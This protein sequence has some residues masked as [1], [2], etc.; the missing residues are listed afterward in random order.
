MVIWEYM[1][2]VG[3]NLAD[4]SLLKIISDFDGRVRTLEL[5][6]TMN[7]LEELISEGTTDPMILKLWKTTLEAKK[8]Q[9]VEHQGVVSGTPETSDDEDEEDDVHDSTFCPVQLQRNSWM[10][11]P[12]ERNRQNF[13]QNDPA[14]QL[15]VPH[16]LITYLKPHEKS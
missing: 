11:S 3:E 12:N 10:L 4:T 9:L 15:M 5:N 7:N 6:R 8:K 16:K 1:S 2:K 14:L 13:Y